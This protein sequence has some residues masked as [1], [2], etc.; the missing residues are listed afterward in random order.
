MHFRS[1]GSCSLAAPLVWSNFLL[2]RWT[3]CRLLSFA[4]S[5]PNA[6]SPALNP[7]GQEVLAPVAGRLEV[8][9][10]SINLPY[11]WDF[12]ML[13]SG[14]GQALPV[15]YRGSLSLVCLP[16]W[17][18]LLDD[19]G[20]IDASPQTRHFRLSATHGEALGEHHTST[21]CTICANERSCCWSFAFDALSHV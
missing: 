1:L 7:S 3:A 10:L 9:R 11:I 13:L 15:P 18:D 4:G 8:T 21:T 19:P 6:A 17:L 5:H 2:R 16:Q 12:F 20:V 14:T